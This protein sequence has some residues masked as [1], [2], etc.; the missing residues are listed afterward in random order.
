MA[1]WEFSPPFVRW[2]RSMLSGFRPPEKRAL[3]IF[4]SL[5]AVALIFVIARA[6]M[7]G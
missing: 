3:V 4:G 1:F 2:E 6:F 5:W 7:P